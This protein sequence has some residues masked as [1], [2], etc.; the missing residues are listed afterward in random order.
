MTLHFSLVIVPDASKMFF[1]KCSSALDTIKPLKIGL[2]HAQYT[3]RN[4]DVKAENGKLKAEECRGIH[5]VKIRHYFF[6]KN[7]G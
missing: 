2:G 4:R 6:D 7:N 3:S 1:E 5:P